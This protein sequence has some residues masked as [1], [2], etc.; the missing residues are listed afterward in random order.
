MN[1]PVDR[2]I[3]ERASM[4]RGFPGSVV[5]S[6][7]VHLLVVGAAAA[8]PFLLPKEP[9][10]KVVDGFAVPMPAGGGGPANPQ[11]QAPAPQPPPSAPPP[12]AEPA[13]EPP[14]KVIKPP[15]EEPRRGL[16]PEDAK[17]GRARP[18]PAPAT[19][20]TG[21]AGAT[22]TSSQTPGLGLVGPAG[23]GV[24]GGTDLLGDWY[25]AGV[26]R[27]IWMIWTQQIRTGHTQPI[28]VS[29]TILAD[30]AVADVQVIQSSGVSLLDLAAQR[31]IYS[32]APFGPLPKDYG[33]N[34][35]TLQALF[36]PVS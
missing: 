29:F 1:D 26:Q 32:A 23:P 36:K 31:A 27:K 35:F 17:K 30:G 7:L 10:I 16:P 15:K 11:A 13:P 34:R 2:V 25:L 14:P 20:S 8:A 5:I 6:V 19:R 3:S 28:G 12:S 33:T 21:A 9:P 24:P 18:T 22:G 4:D